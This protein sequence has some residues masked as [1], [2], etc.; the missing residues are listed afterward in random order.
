MTKLYQKLNH[1]Q[2]GKLFVGDQTQSSLYIIV[3][4]NNDIRVSNKKLRTNIE[5]AL[6]LSESDSNSSDS[7]SSKSEQDQS[8]SYES[9]ISSDENSNHSTKSKHL[10]TSDDSDRES[11][12]RNNINL[13][14]QNEKGD[15]LHKEC[16]LP[17]QTSTTT[18]GKTSNKHQSKTKDNKVIVSKSDTAAR[19]E[20]FSQQKQSDRDNSVRIDTRMT[21]KM[22][23]TSTK[24]LKRKPTENF[25]TD[26]PLVPCKKSKVS[27]ITDETDDEDEPVAS[28]S[29]QTVENPKKAKICVKL[30]KADYSSSGLSV[31]S[32]VCKNRG[33]SL[34][35]MTVKQKNFIQEY[36]IGNKKNLTKNAFEDMIQTFIAMTTLQNNET[37]SL[38]SLKTWHGKLLTSKKNYETTYEQ[39]QSEMDRMKNKHNGCVEKLCEI[40]DKMESHIVQF[41]T[42]FDQEVSQRN[43]KQCAIHCLSIFCSKLKKP[44]G[45]PSKN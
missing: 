41:N 17:V 25:E 6:Q 7:E 44:H 13:G 10:D 27:I 37:R 4:S 11:I 19:T 34:K 3:T 23:P 16:S 45:R 36:L 35:N 18:H 22:P 42:F 43:C 31:I 29:K 24:K 2:H 28:T 21:M 5:K 15:T 14:S 12:V 40:M 33:L 32:D 8:E 39:V 30:N 1:W 20:K 38:E 26:M 9:D